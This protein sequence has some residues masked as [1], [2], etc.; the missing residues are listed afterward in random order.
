MTPAIAERPARSKGW[1]DRYAALAEADACKAVAPAVGAHDDGIT[2]FKEAARLAGWK[3]QWAPAPRRDLEQA[4]EPVIAR[5]RD[6]PRAEQIAGA[7]I[8]AA[9][10][11]VRRQLGHGPV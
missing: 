10:A 8:A 6:R 1:G 3:R 5:R 7:Q 11:V 9:A 4:A 2:V